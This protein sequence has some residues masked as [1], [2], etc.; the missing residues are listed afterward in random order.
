M[1][2]Q[3][4]A[5]QPGTTGRSDPVEQPDAA[6]RSAPDSR[7][8][9]EQEWPAAR[10]AGDIALY[11]LA[12]LGMLVVVAAVLT[13]LGVPFL[14]AAAVSVV[15]VMP[16]SMLVFGALRRRVATGIAVRKQA[17]QARREALRAELR[18]EG[19]GSAGA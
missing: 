13:L 19:G 2:E 11:T 10:L 3:E 16:V 9:A 6:E 18:G 14:V 8:S 1:R 12:R 5:E 7:Q 17:R 4:S 15:V